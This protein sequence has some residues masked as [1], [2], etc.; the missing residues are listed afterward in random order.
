MELN[1][2]K[3]PIKDKKGNVKMYW[4]WNY[5]GANNKPLA[6]TKINKAKVK[7]KAQTIIKEIGF[8][9]TSTHEVLLN[10]AYESFE[11]RL[12]YKIREGVIE[13]GHARDYGSFYANHILPYFNNVD[14]RNL[15][16]QEIN[17]FVKYLTDKLFKNEL[18][19]K[20]IRKIFNTLSAILQNQVDPPNRKINRNICKDANWMTM[21]VTSRTK[22]E[23]IDF[24][25][26]NMDLMKNIIHN[27][28]RYKVQLICKILLECALRPS[29]A[30]CLTIDDLLNFDVS[31]NL[32][33]IIDINKSVKSG[34]KKIGDPKTDNGFRQ[35]VISNDLR[36][37]I[38]KYV[39]TLPKDQ[40]HLFL[41][42]TNSPIRLEAII[43]GMDKSLNKLDLTLPIKR[44]GYFWRHYTASFW[45]YT[46]KYKNAIDLAKALGDKSID[47]V[48]ENYI[49]LYLKSEKEVENVDYQNKHFNWK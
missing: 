3:V 42:K 40:K 32:P 12:K 26:W 31:S 1:L 45:A 29:E 19:A 21:V 6:I 2:N 14:I 10:E 39:K 49:A 18:K 27:I 7:E 44:K 43:R 24:D 11:K 15:G 20:T 37:E 4:R 13:V 22:P 46:S 33:P 16:E 35:L 9:K 38:N 25:Y 8:I 30:R 5:I 23:R 36:D 41:D 34:T 47:F 28:P 17:G 48:Q